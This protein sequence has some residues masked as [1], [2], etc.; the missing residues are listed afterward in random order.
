MTCITCALE[1]CAFDVLSNG[2]IS[3]DGTLLSGGSNVYGQLGREVHNLEM[4]PVNIGFLPLSI[5]SGYGHSLAICQ[6]KSVEVGGDT[7][8][9]IVSWGWNHSSQLGRV[10]A[11]NVP[12]VV[13][14]LEGEIP[15]SVSGGRAHSIALTS[16]REVWVW[17]CGKNGRLGLGSSID[18][19][20]P[21]LV[22]CLE[23]CE[24]LQAVAGFDHNL[25]L[26][27]E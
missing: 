16:K 11:N 6:F 3:G 8:T 17:G 2:W 24:V 4:L 5:A 7:T 27:S 15:I 18:E 9:T 26:I 22:E 14:G 25:V 23:G 1:T 10:G 19:I 13:E 21:C 12:L 20:E